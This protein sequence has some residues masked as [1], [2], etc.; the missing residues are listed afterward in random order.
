[1]LPDDNPKT[2]EGVKKPSFACVPPV[3]LLHLAHAMMSGANKYGR[4]NWRD[5]IVTSSIYYDA[6]MRHLLSWAD[7]ETYDRESSAHHLAHV[8]ACCAILLDAES[9]SR[10]NDDRSGSS[11]IFADICQQV[12]EDTGT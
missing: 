12:S 7:G 1:M 2:A 4:M 5:H 11:R 3:A 10:L 8:M 6:M 9:L